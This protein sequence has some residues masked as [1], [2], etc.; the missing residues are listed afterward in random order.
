[1]AFV[2]LYKNL[3]FQQLFYVLWAV[4]IIKLKDFCFN[5]KILASKLFV[6]IGKISYSLY[7][8][9]QAVIT[10]IH[11]DSPYLALG[12]AITGILFH[13]I[14]NKIRVSK[15]PYIVP[16]ILTFGLVILALGI[17]ALIA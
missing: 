6:F 7:I 16:A 12:V 2:F 10:F 1:V 8:W 5:K 11:F 4:M 13:P 17:I 15:H 3:E 14:E 9:H